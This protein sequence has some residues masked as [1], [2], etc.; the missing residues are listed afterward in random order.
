L[1]K[2]D[3]KSQ[4][5]WYGSNCWWKIVFCQHG[6]FV[7]DLSCTIRISRCIWFTA[8]FVWYETLRSDCITSVEITLHPATADDAK[9][10]YVKLQLQFTFPDKVR[11][12]CLKKRQGISYRLWNWDVQFILHVSPCLFVAQCWKEVFMCSIGRKCVFLL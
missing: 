1:H 12:L 9:T 2:S 10:Q 4:V 11:G 8:E 7:I 3:D 5:I 6:I